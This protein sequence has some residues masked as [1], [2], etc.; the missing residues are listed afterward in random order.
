M[1]ISIFKDNQLLWLLSQH[2]KITNC[3]ANF[4]TVSIQK[5]FSENVKNKSKFF[6]KSYFEYPSTKKS[7]HKITESTGGWKARQDILNTVL[8][9]KHHCPPSSNVPDVIQ[10]SS[11]KVGN[12]PQS[13]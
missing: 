13:F 5:I 11:I 3:Y 2:S 4:S 8:L 10:K 12:K 7:F 6:P 9:K 1:N